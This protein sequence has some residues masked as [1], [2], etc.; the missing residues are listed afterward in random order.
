MY[1]YIY[2]YIYMREW[3]FEYSVIVT[4]KNVW[5]SP[6]TVLWTLL[7]NIHNYVGKDYN[8]SSA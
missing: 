7:G 6:L 2:I 3:E 8:K 1:V 4:L 5:V